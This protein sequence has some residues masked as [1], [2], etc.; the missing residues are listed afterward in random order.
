MS[1]TPEQVVAAYS[2]TREQ[3]DALKTEF[4]KQCAALKATQEKREAWLKANLTESDHCAFIDPATEQVVAGKFP[5][6]ISD[7]MV[8]R[9]V[10]D[11]DQLA[12]LSKAASEISAPLNA[13]Q[14]ARAQWFKNELTS[15]GEEGM[16]TVHGTVFWE[17][18]ASATV[19]DANAFMDWVL[20]K[21]RFV[22][23]AAYLEGLD[24][25]AS[26]LLTTALSELEEH[27]SFL[28]NAVNK[29]AVKARLDAVSDREKELKARKSVPAEDIPKVLAQEFGSPVPP[30][31]N[32]STF[33]DVKVRR[34]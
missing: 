28:N 7:Y 26:H 25:E 14:M 6:K 5:E 4:D 9:Y 15:R 11:R 20:A 1:S 3:L 17:T 32:Y 33:K 16:K 29:T 10:E 13:A 21:D 23:L 18:V 34:K 27:R 22:A 31:V 12:A 19:A 2:K 8:Q 24:A 30:G